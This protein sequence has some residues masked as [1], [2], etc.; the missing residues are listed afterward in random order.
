[1]SNWG[2]QRVA[3]AMPTAAPV[4]PLNP[5]SV[6][7]AVVGVL[8]IP[9][10]FGAYVAGPMSNSGCPQEWAA[11]G[12]ARVAREC[13]PDERW[14]THFQTFTVVAIIVA[15]VVALVV[16]I[17]AGHRELVYR[18][19]GCALALVVVLAVPL[20]AAYGIGRGLGRL[21]VRRRRRYRARVV[22]R[23]GT[24][25]A[26]LTGYEQVMRA[27]D[28]VAVLAQ[29]AARP[30]GR[31]GGHVG[32]T[33]T[34]EYISANPR[35]GV[36]VIGPPGSGK[37]SAIIIPSTAVAPGACVS[38]SMKGDVM[39]ATWPIRAR[40][41]VVWHFDPGGE[42]QPPAGVRAAR[43]SPLVSV[44]TWDDARRIA[45][46]MAAGATTGDESGDSH[47]TDRARDWVEVLL[48]AAHLGG[49]PISQVA[50]WA[51][52]AAS[53]DTQTA[54]LELL[55]TAEDAGDLGASIAAQQ[56][57]GLLATADRERSSII[58]TMSRLLR[59][60]GSVAARRIGEDPTFDPHAFVRSTD[61]LYITASP[62]RQAEYAPLLAGL[63]EEIRFAVYARHKAE[64]EGRE[65]RRPH[66]T[67]VLD[68]A[69]NTAPIPLPAIISEAGGQSLHI[70]V[71]IQ[72]LS[73]A[74]QRWG[75]E[76]DGFLTLFP[77]KI[78]LSGVVEP[79]TLDA[80][81][82]AAGEYDRLMVGYSESTQFVGQF[83]TR[84]T[85]T[86]PSWSIHRQKV[87]HQGDIA[88]LPPGTALLWEGAQW[89][90][91]NIGMHWAHPVWQRTLTP[92]LP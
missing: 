55:L 44:R 60:Y 3:V 30:F 87:L 78:V 64:D 39:G 5:W 45:T 1:M 46:R 58:S 62:D 85:Q 81:S 24:A 17:H 51:A 66:V 54:V 69:N 35:G 76:A 34:G 37:S 53:D 19:S 79:Y 75:K 59:I 42:E 83:N 90:L 73:R 74:R 61:T 63:L 86:N 41:G 23:T 71:G 22:A 21:Q 20:F 88:N 6:V 15:S 8:A 26:V 77:T 56:F 89:H 52:L 48:Y 28:P 49:R 7:A 25:A 47:F 32:W 9:I 12:P 38:N 65:P 68:E 91:I 14:V 27:V 16:G 13:G 10:W 50:Q 70:I 40:L 82:N 43:W 36:L 29:V 57:Q 18:E 11:D 84:V 31:A 2:P 80:L 33:N 67:F 72:D 92:A 4:L